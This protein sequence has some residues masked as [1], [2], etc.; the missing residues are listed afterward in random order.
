MQTPQGLL[1]GIAREAYLGERR[2]TDAARRLFGEVF[3]HGEGGRLDAASH[4]RD[5]P[6]IEESLQSPVLTAGAV[7]SGEDDVRAV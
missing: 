5:A 6:G 2:D 7:N 1:G 3:V 4:I